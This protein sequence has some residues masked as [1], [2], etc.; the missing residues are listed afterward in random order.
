M[1]VDV[2]LSNTD[3]L[4][5]IIND[6]LDISK[7]EAGKLSLNPRS[8]AI[9]DLVRSSMQSVESI[10]VGATVT[11]VPRIPN[12]TPRVMADPDRTVQA[13]VNFLSNALKY[14]PP[15]SN[16]TVDVSLAGDTHVRL[17]VTDHGRGIPADKL[18]SLFQ[19][20]QQVDNA[21]TRKFRGTGLGLAITKALIE[22]QGGH[23]FV[24]STVGEGSTFSLTI[25]I[26]HA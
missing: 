23:V 10:A 17:A 2:A 20:F 9:A 1:L 6:I 5:R 21:D 18:D 7:I 22:M 14:A 4:I 26:A 13:I 24:E 16:V 19:K 15:R 8:C 3:R 12:D 11:I 25:P